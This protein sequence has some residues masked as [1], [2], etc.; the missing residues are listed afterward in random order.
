MV[1]NY[2]SSTIVVAELFQGLV[3]ASLHGSTQAQVLE[4]NLVEVEAEFQVSDDPVK[5]RVY[6]EPELSSQ[7]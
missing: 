7:V 3:D 6:A 5:S 4:N 1:V 2:N